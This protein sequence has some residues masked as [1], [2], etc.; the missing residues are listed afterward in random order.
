M[1][2][3]HLGI[4][5]VFV[6]IELIHRAEISLTHAHDDDREGKLRAIDDLI[7][8]LLKVRNDAI[9][10]DEQDV[11]LLVL[12]GAIHLLSHFIDYF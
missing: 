2:L 4:E 1:L 7:D 9:C 6:C 12:L 3:V 10:Y 5:G 11:V 8:S